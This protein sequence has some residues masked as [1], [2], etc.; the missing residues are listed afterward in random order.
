MNIGTAKPSL[1][2]RDGVVHHLI[3]ILSPQ[4][5]YSVA[6]F[7]RDAQCAIDKV[8]AKGKLPILAGGT[9]M[10]FNALVN[11]L[12]EMPASDASIREQ[13]SHMDLS[14]VHKQLTAVDVQSAKRINQSD[15]QRL[16]RAL[17]V[18][19]VSGKP[20]TYWQG[21]KKIK[22]PYRFMQ[23]SIIPQERSALHKIIQ[24]RFDDMLTA[25]LVSEVEYLLSS[26]NLDPDMPSM[27]SV[28]YRQVWE[29]LQGKLDY[30]EMREK[31]IIA[32]RQLAKRQL[33]W[34]RGWQQITPL[35]SG[36]SNN[37]QR[38]VQKVGATP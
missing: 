10:Y 21:L 25:G 23:F 24:H 8:L 34:L 19:M 16:T 3:D 29:Y 30:D 12:N 22:L 32:T 6:D 27:R 15:A 13:I 9:M 7:M 14:E 17:E 35:K 20:L 33:T 11:G 37:L 28:G 18:Y 31:G 38:L 26:F 4:F 5:S 36:D 2:Q 1:A